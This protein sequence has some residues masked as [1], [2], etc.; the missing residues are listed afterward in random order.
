MTGKIIDKETLLHII[1]N[2][3]KCLGVLKLTCSI[4]SAEENPNLFYLCP[5]AEDWVS[6]APQGR[7][8]ISQL[9]RCQADLYSKAIELF[10]ENYGID[11]LVEELL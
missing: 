9:S 1:K 10:I 2:S 7:D 11:G 8:N 3:G 6:D 5:V 4:S